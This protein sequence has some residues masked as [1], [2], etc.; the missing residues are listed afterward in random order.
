[1]NALD[2]LLESVDVVVS[3]PAQDAATLEIRSNGL[4]QWDLIPSVPSG[5]GGDL[6]ILNPHGI[7]ET[8]L[9]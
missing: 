4:V 2:A 5:E 3:K 6:A 7:Q 1:M 8:L 9:S